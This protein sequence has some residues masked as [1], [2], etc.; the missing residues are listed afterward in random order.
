[1]IR[2]VRREKEGER[3]K[4]GSVCVRVREREREKER[5]REGGEVGGGRREGVEIRA[6]VVSS[7]RRPPAASCVNSA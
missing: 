5:E 4:G 6:A 7:A 2:L 1:M 3:K